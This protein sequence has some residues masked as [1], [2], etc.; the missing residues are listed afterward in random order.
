MTGNAAASSAKM[1]EAAARFSCDTRLVYDW[2]TYE[3]A[4]SD[5]SGL[6]AGER[7]E[8]LI[9]A[10]S[11]EAE[12]LSIEEM[13]ELFVFSWP[14]GR[15]WADKDKDRLLSLLRFIA[16][17]RVSETYLSGEL[18]I[19]RAGED[20]HGIL[21]T[22]DEGAATAE[23]ADGT[24]FSATIPSDDVLAHFTGGGRNEV[25]VEPL[26][27]SSIEQAGHGRAHHLHRDR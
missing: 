10:W 26:S 22:L 21:W 5:L 20:A 12:L 11:E 14:D 4:M 1:A 15:E 3:Q 8:A 24:L 27:L 23:A 6:P 2:R 9:T 18:A 17:V 16:P 19:F 13:R 25:L 7:L